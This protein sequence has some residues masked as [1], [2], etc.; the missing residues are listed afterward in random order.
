[1]ARVRY[2]KKVALKLKT[3]LIAPLVYM[4][5]TTYKRGRFLVQAS[6]KEV[7]VRKHEIW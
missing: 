5:V 6:V 4:N 3:S 2:I 1:M 7:D